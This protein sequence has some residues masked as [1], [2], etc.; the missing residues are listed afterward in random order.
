[1]KTNARSTNKSL[2]RFFL[3]T[4]IFTLPTYALVGL[5]ANNRILSPEMAFAFI[6]LSTLAPIG[7]AL[8]LVFWGR[9]QSRH[10]GT[11]MEGLRLQKNS[12]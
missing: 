8:L 9:W 3:L 7:T 5:A 6:P 1:M 10:E 2:I 4:F 12:Q 11:P